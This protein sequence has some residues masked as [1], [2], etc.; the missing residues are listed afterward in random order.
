MTNSTTAGGFLLVLA[1]VLPV[2]GVLLS[3][4]LGGRQAERVA[5][6]VM[7][8]ELVVAVAIAAR[9]WHTHDILQYLVGGWIPPLGVAFRADGLSAVMIVT[10]A[11]LICKGDALRLPP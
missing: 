2:V 1:I 3:L 4:A 11:V 6:V 5:F 8:A 9:I 7:P 10:S